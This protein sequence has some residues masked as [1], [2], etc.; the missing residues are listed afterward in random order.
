MER[1]D[2]EVDPDWFAL[3]GNFERTL[4]AYA[5]SR[6]SLGLEAPRSAVLD[7]AT[8]LSKCLHMSLTLEQ[9]I[10]RAATDS[11]KTFAFPKGESQ[12]QEIGH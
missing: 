8:T 12:R 2:T 4:T 3:A 10:E 5:G 7:L 1:L 11:A 6:S 9:V